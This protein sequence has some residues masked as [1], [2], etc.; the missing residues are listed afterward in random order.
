VR[1]A[2]FV[3]LIGDYHGRMSSPSNS[4]PAIQLPN[5]GRLLGFTNPHPPSN[6]C[7]GIT[8][9]QTQVAPLIVSMSCQLKILKLLKPLIDI[10]HGLPAPPVGALEEFSK[11]A[12]DLAPCLLIPTP[13]GLLP[14]VHDLLCMEIRSLNCLLESLQSAVGQPGADLSSDSKPLVRSILD[15]YQ[16]IV[17]TLNLATEFFETAG[18]ALPEA[19][20]LGNGTDLASVSTDQSAILAFMSRLQSVADVIGGCS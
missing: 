11:A 8:N 19:P 14:F 12:I 3:A 15:S 9:L 18:L 7:S 2:S 6:E 17:G 10:I 4:A 1:A 13:S 16:P 5:G 20:V